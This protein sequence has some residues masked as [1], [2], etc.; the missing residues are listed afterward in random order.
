MQEPFLLTR[1]GPQIR[2][3]D[4]ILL[5]AFALFLTTN[6]VLGVLVLARGLIIPS[7]IWGVFQ[8]GNGV[9]AA[10]LILRSIIVF[11][12]YKWDPPKGNVHTVAGFV[13]G[14]A[15]FWLALSLSTP[16]SSAGNPWGLTPV[17]LLVGIV[18]LFTA[19]IHDAL[20][21]PKQPTASHPSS[22]LWQT[23]PPRETTTECKICHEPGIYDICQ[24]CRGKYK[25]ERQRVQYHLNRARQA[26]EP[27]TLTLPEWIEILDT[28]NYRCA[29]C[30]DGVYQVLEHRIPIGQ[31][32]TYKGGTTAINCVPACRSCNTIKSN[33][34]PHDQ[35]GIPPTSK[36]QKRY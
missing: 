31:G 35:P 15:L 13:A 4:E 9:C 2:K 16:S 17:I 24:R 28:H 1:I 6:I 20:Q 21:H 33:R 34:H 25:D 22:P 36:R 26:K 11:T 19:E 5:I 14:G 7:W 23:I 3:F 10:F 8:W 30:P 32:S 12:I 18:M 27:A 29:Y